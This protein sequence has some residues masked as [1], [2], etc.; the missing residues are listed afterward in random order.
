MLSQLKKAWAKVRSTFATDVTKANLKNKPEM[1]LAL[2]ISAIIII[3][4]ASFAK[5]RIFPPAA[6]Y[7]KATSPVMG[8]L[9]VDV[10]VTA[11]VSFSKPVINV[12]NTTVG[13]R[14][15]V[16]DAL[17][18]ATVSYN[19]STYQASIKPNTP[20][21]PGTQYYYFVSANITDG[22]GVAMSGWNYYNK[23]DH[24]FTTATATVSGGVTIPIASTNASLP[25]FKQ[26]TG[27][28]YDVTQHGVKANDVVD[29][30]AAV[31]AAIN[32][33]PAGYYAYFPAGNYVFKNIYLKSNATVVLDKA[34]NVTPP[35]ATVQSDAFIRIEGSSSGPAYVTNVTV[36]GGNFSI[37][38]GSKIQFVRT[39]YADGVYLS[40]VKTTAP[41]GTYGQ[42]DVFAI[43]FSKNIHARNLDV[44]GGENGY[45]YTDS[46]DS[47]VAYSSFKGTGLDGVLVYHN[48]ARII[49]DNNTVDGYN[50]SVT[51]GR[52][53]IHCYKASD[54]RFTNNRVLNSKGN[55]TGIR[56]RDSE[57]FTATGNY[58]ENTLGGNAIGIVRIGDW[59]LN[60]GNGTI[61]NNTII[62]AG[63][64]GIDVISRKDA[65]GVELIKPVKVLNNKITKVYRST[66]TTSQGANNGIQVLNKGSVVTGNTIASTSGYCV[67]YSAGVTVSG[68]SYSAC[69]LGNTSLE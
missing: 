19:S 8:T 2:F 13:I 7:V 66:A 18:P 69:Q 30:S 12:N 62:A 54:C 55:A 35:G 3:G 23:A 48:T 50:V 47:E 49:V 41:M 22:Y 59:N 58:V 31:Q 38:A 29:D 61:E 9:N 4:G 64:Q 10:D 68:N 27:N 45:A 6:P 1:L 63:Y 67:V 57:V 16:G 32:S 15:Y 11:L 39:Y 65:N 28:P 51:E 24:A 33:V 37:P 60:G 5:R 34:A 20:L 26:P 56:F 42:G 53:G 43:M 17:L 14:N 46:T 25:A 40:Y 36:I 52:A 44:T 21:A